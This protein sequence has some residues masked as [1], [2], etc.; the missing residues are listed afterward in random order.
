MLDLHLVQEDISVLGDLDIS[1]AG[2]EHL[3]GSLRTQVGLEHVL[4]PLGG[5][6]ID[7]QRLRGPGDL[8]LRVQQ[9]NGGHGER[10]VRTR[11]R[12]VC[13]NSEEYIA[14][15]G[16]ATGQYFDVSGLGGRSVRRARGRGQTLLGR[17][18]LTCK[19]LSNHASRLQQS[20]VA[21]CFFSF[22]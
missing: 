2:D 1:G 10:A 16:I 14:S 11:L 20:A 6:D 5:G 8:G 13:K 3:H 17:E 21:V 4:N 18:V 7:G 22:A 12:R 19:I 15:A 9:R